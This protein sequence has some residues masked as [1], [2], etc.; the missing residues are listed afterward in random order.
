MVN[1]KAPFTSRREKERNLIRRKFHQYLNSLHKKRK[2]PKNSNYNVIKEP[3]ESKILYWLDKEFLSQNEP[4]NSKK[5][6]EIEIP[7]TLCFSRDPDGAIAFLKHVY[8]VANNIKT[9]TLT[10][11]FQKCKNLDIAA[12]AI[13]D[14]MLYDVFRRRYSI[15]KRIKYGR[16][17]TD[18]RKLS[19][20][21]EIDTLLKASGIEKHFGLYKQ[22]F[23]N[24]KVLG[25]IIDGD[26]PDVSEKIIEYIDKSLSAHGFHLSESGHNYFGTIVGEITDNC[27]Y[28]SGDNSTWI[29]QG[30]YY[31][32]KDKKIGK[33]KLTILDFGNTI[34]EGLKS[35]ATD[36]TSR[37]IELFRKSLSASYRKSIP[38]ETMYS[39]LALQQSVSRLNSKHKHRGD[40]TIKF[41]D[42]FQRIFA[43]TEGKENSILSIT[44]GKCSILFDGTYIAKEQSFE[45]GKSNK[46]IAFNKE[47]DLHEKPDEKYVRTLQNSFP[48][49]IIT[50]EL[51]I[52]NDLLV[53][54]RK[55]NAGN[56]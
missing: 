46:I 50:M 34:Y 43:T 6:E 26:S 40:G 32:D 44:S 54:R 41:L 38:E 10:F 5:T 19:E 1:M 23:D 27:N 48:G 37:G 22:N 16:C 3:Y 47:N 42:A 51:Y 18:G 33:C 39:V 15:K 35:G 55:T 7:E 24:V 8:L 36:E 31:Y 45:E 21:K 14:I 49:T 25:M 13:L 17:L 12:S 20:D 30:H 52:D 29:T 9:E 28:H 53:I 56:K 11:D 2:H 4:V